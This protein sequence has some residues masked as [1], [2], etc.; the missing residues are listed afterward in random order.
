MSGACTQL[1][2]AEGISICLCW[3][4]ATICLRIYVP[5]YSVRE[6]NLEILVGV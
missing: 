2:T 5:V 4:D 1:E 6:L 3:R